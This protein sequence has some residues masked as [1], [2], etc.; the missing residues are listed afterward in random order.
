[1]ATTKKDV[2]DAYDNWPLSP[3]YVW[4]SQFSRERCF[5]KVIDEG[6]C[7]LGNPEFAARL[8]SWFHDAQESVACQIWLHYDPSDEQLRSQIRLEVVDVEDNHEADWSHDIDSLIQVYDAANNWSSDL[9]RM[10]H[11]TS[12]SLLHIHTVPD[13]EDYHSPRLI[14]DMLHI[15][16]SSKS[17]IAVVVSLH[18]DWENPGDGSFT[19]TIPAHISSNPRLKQRWLRMARR[20][21]EASRQ[22]PMRGVRRRI[23]ILSTDR[24]SSLMRQSVFRGLAGNS[25][26]YASWHPLNEAQIEAL[27]ESPLA[28]IQSTVSPGNHDR[29]SIDE[30]RSILTSN[31]CAT[32]VPHEFENDHDDIPF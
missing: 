31:H 1:M 28:A 18:F 17:P 22:R 19:L 29:I 11:W 3:V 27:T 6:N 26:A 14:V 10:H 13:E 21:Q 20:R 15:I 7:I 32:L 30:A 16:R 25:P 12:G 24:V 8:F 9:H 23:A 4:H 2:F 5:P